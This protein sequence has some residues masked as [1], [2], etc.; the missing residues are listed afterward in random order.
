MVNIKKY[1]PSLLAGVLAVILVLLLPDTFQKILAW[2]DAHLWDIL[3]VILCIALVLIV[4]GC[5]YNK[6]K[7]GTFLRPSASRKK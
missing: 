5:T 6:I 3:I 7:Y 2:K 1:I 4:F